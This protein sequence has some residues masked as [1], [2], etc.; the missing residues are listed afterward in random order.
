MTLK[1]LIAG[2]WMM[3]ITRPA[4]PSARQE[5]IAAAAGALRLPAVDWNECELKCNEKMAE[6]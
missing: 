3:I 4:S 5:K 1:G 2:N 6:A